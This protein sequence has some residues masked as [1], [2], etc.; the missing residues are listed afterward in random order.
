MATPEQQ[1]YESHAHHPVRSYVAGFFSLIAFILLVGDWLFGWRTGPPGAVAL[2]LS[3]FVLVSISRTYITRLQDRV[4]QLEMRVRLR[5]VL[6]ASQHPQIVELTKSQL[7]GLRFAD[8]AEL[9]ALVDRAVRERLSKKD[10]KRA[11]TRWVP[12]RDRT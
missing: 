12:D 6:P 9:G 3:V 8:D 11:I 4:I 7:V 2:A 1:S 10:I 5:D